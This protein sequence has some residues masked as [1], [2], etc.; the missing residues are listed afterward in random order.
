[1]HV[2]TWNTTPRKRKFGG[3]TISLIPLR[4]FSYLRSAHQSFNSP[5]SPVLCFFFLYSFLLHVFSYHIA[6]PQFWS[7]YVSVSIDFHVPCS[8]FSNTLIIWVR[9]QTAKVPKLLNQDKPIIYEAYV[10]E[11][12][13]IFI[14]Y[15]WPNQSIQAMKSDVYKRTHSLHNKV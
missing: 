10:A 13:P 2:I 7:S 3:P 14:V 4:P 5:L 15:T 12:R 9:G 6:P 1:M 11:W 8:T